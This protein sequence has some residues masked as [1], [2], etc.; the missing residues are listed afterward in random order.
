MI[1]LDKE[2]QEIDAIIREA[3]SGDRIATLCVVIIITIIVAGLW[4]WLL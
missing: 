2:R 3:V 4:R 1:D